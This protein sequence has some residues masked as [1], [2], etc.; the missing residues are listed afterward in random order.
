MSGE[1]R[2]AAPEIDPDV[3]VKGPASYFSSIEKTYGQ[4]IQP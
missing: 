4:P 2:V 1:R 3:P